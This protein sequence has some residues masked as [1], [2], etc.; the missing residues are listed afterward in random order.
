MNTVIDG[1]SVNT[2]MSIVMGGITKVFVGELIE[3]GIFLLKIDCQLEQ[4]WKIGE[5]LV[6]YVQ[7]TCGKATGWCLNF[8]FLFKTT[9]SE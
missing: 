9:E 8:E 7:D 3:E 5:K 6:L 2:K 4:R 1:Q